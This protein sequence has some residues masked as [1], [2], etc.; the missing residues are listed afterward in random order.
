MR[1]PNDAAIASDGDY[2][3]FMIT[4]VIAG[5]PESIPVAD[6]DARKDEL[7]SQAGAADFVSF[8][9]ELERRADIERSDDALDQQDF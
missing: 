7:E 8:V 4:A 1:L 2:V 3:V 9:S 5:R 6:R